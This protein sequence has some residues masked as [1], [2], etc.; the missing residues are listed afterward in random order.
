[1][2]PNS[3][4]RRPT[5]FC[6]DRDR[7]VGG[8]GSKRRVCAGC[9]RQR[10]AVGGGRDDRPLRCRATYLPNVLFHSSCIAAIFCGVKSESFWLRI[11]TCNVPGTLGRI[12]IAFPLIAACPA[13]E[14]MKSASSC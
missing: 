3:K 11:G 5:R 7:L 8:G 9:E 12:E 4:M 13:R 6:G 14:T 2:R 10:R 1:C